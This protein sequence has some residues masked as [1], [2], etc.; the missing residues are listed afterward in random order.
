MGRAVDRIPVQNFHKGSDSI[1]IDFTKKPCVFSP[2]I[3][4]LSDTSLIRCQTVPS[5]S[6]THTENSTVSWWACAGINGRRDVDGQWTHTELAE[7]VCV[8]VREHA[9]AW[10]SELWR[11]TT[12]PCLD[13][14]VVL[15]ISTKTLSEI[16]MCAAVTLTWHSNPILQSNIF[17]CHFSLW[18]S[19]ITATLTVNIAT[20]IFLHNTPVCDECITTPSLATKDPVFHIFLININADFKCLLWPW[21]QKQPYSIFTWHLGVWWS[22]IKLG[23]VPRKSVQKI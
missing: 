5:V 13:Q 4:S 6:V 15:Q 19:T 11:C 1:M 22:T 9:C 2:W 17:M 10:H 7:N 3:T 23:L 8:C 21:P 14:I 20:E 12:I 18:W 16:W